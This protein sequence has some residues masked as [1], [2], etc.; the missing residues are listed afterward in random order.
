MQFRTIGALALMF[1]VLAGAAKAETIGEVN[2]T[3]NLMAPNDKIK[4][5]AF[6]DPK[7]E[8]VTCYVSK[9]ERGGWASVVGMEEDTSDASIA[10]R[11]TGSLRI[12]ENLNDGE[13]VFSE[14]RSILFKKLHV[15][16]FWDEARNTLVYL[17]YSDK[18]I[19]GSPKNAVSAV[20]PM[21]WGT[22]MPDLS[23]MGK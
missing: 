18:L 6:E 12:R 9:A 3:F 22:Q 2:T 20:T 1:S 10:C 7:V 21:P 19:D 16:R 4:I 13:Q 11:Q 8:G 14:R 17:T 23:V 15:V 5:E